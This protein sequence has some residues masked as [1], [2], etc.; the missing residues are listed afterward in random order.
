MVRREIEEQ[1]LYRRHPEAF[2]LALA[3]QAADATDHKRFR[4]KTLKRKQNLFRGA[5]SV[6]TYFLIVS[7]QITPLVTARNNTTF[8][9]ALDYINRTFSFAPPP[10]LL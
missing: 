7:C 3:A 5:K 1:P 8:I 6:P 4:G 9:N 2:S 10:P